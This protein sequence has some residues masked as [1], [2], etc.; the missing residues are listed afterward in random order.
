MG[1]EISSVAHAGTRTVSLK[2]QILAF[3]ES[4]T[5]SRPVEASSRG[6]EPGVEAARAPAPGPLLPHQKTLN[7]KIN[8]TVSVPVAMALVSGKGRNISSST[9]AACSLGF[10]P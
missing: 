3:S 5:C 4:H 1:S 2:R 9:R 6:G 7:I 8:N 10:G